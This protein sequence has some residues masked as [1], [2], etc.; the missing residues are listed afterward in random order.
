MLM[1]IIVH[2]RSDA[3][4]VLLYYFQ[5]RRG[6]LLLSMGLTCTDQKTER[7]TVRIRRVT[8]GFR[9]GPKSLL[10]KVSKGRFYATNYSH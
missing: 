8:V 9:D 7:L 4:V 3:Q 1:V 10:L 6:L 5:E 2:N